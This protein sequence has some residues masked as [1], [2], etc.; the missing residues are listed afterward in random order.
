MS[1]LVRW[2]TP[3]TDEFFPSV[4]LFIFPDYEGKRDSLMA[5]VTPVGVDAYPKY[6]V[7]FG[8]VLAFTCLEESYAPERGYT[9]ASV[10]TNDKICAWQ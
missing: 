8:E 3:F 4:N 2:D 9:H 10:S 5:I 1:K 6:V 7:R